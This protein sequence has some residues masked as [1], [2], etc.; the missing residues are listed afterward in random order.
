MY[1]PLYW[2]ISMLVHLVVSSREANILIIEL[3]SFGNLYNSVYRHLQDL[4]ANFTTYYFF[5]KL[6]HDVQ[7]LKNDFDTLTPGFPCLGVLLQKLEN[8][9][10]R[11]CLKV[12]SNEV[13]PFPEASF[14]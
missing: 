13:R 8:P 12:P 10:L 3:L 2:H 6:N 9:A 5:A 7:K 11:T 1:I 4:S 14:K